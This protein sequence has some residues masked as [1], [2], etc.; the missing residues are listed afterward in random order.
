MVV[1]L[2]GELFELCAAGVD[3]VIQGPLGSLQVP[4]L[5]PQGPGLLPA[6][7]ASLKHASH[8]AA[9]GREKTQQEGKNDGD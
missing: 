2:F 1:F 7:G 9:T 6:T 8:P 4:Q 3:Q 5:S